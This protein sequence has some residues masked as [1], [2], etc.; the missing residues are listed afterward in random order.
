MT[1]TFSLLLVQPCVTTSIKH[2]ISTSP[3]RLLAQ[4]QRYV[5]V[6]WLTLRRVTRLVAL[7]GGGG[8]LMP[9]A[10]CTQAHSI[11]THTHTCVYTAAPRTCRPMH[12]PR[13][14]A[15]HLQTLAWLRLRLATFR[16]Q[17]KVQVSK[18]YGQSSLH[19][20]TYTS[21]VHVHVSPGSAGCVQ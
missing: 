21:R 2:I 19:M 13:Y 9:A 12:M 5:F 11:H 8:G 16:H 7:T 17:S 6:R 14:A 20:C 3:T 10:D 1:S 18:N 4:A 15:S